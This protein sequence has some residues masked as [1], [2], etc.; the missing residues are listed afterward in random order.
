MSPEV[1]NAGCRE[2]LLREEP[3]VIGSEV[4]SVRS[5]CPSTVI[6]F[7]TPLLACEVQELSSSV[8]SRSTSSTSTSPSVSSSPL[9]SSSVISFTG[10]QCSETTGFSP[11][12]NLFFD[13]G[14]QD[15]KNTEFTK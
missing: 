7:G 4:P 5:G 9:G 13:P 10:R 11:I 2:I 6:R 14:V 3:E 12:T 15:R 1:N 8:C